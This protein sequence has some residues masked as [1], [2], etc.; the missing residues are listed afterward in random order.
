MRDAVV[1]T[2]AHRASIC[3]KQKKK[4]TG[5]VWS[6]VETS[7]QC[8]QTVD[9]PPT[10]RQANRSCSSYAETGPAPGGWS[11]ARN[12]KRPVSSLRGTG[13]TGTRKRKAQDSETH[14]LRRRRE[15]E[16]TSTRPT[17]RT[18]FHSKLFS[19]NCSSRAGFGKSRLT[20][21]RCKRGYRGTRH[22]RPTTVND[23]RERLRRTWS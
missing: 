11:K 7:K 4:R 22:A 23:E 3:D 15:Q 16:N 14:W 1:Y 9:V 10:R 20:G 21:N 5:Q 18:G 12:V 19:R 2:Q 17:L 6:L 13:E 8:H